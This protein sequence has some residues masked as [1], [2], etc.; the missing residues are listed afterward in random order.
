MFV[1]TWYAFGPEIGVTFGEEL[2][3]ESL[4]VFLDGGW[5]CGLLC[6]FDTD[7][8]MVAVR[9]RVEST[10]YLSYECGVC[11]TSAPVLGECDTYEP[12]NV[13]CCYHG[14]CVDDTCYFDVTET[15]LSP[16]C[17]LLKE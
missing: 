17:S 14:L 7:T 15:T 11:D 13:S 3:V 12:E 5:D 6:E 8:F 9:V 16:V 2:H 1:S 4:V 10:T